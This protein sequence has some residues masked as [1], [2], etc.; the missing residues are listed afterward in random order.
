MTVVPAYTRALALLAI[1]ISAAIA[2]HPAHAQVSQARPGDSRLTSLLTPRIGVEVGA[3]ATSSTALQSAHTAILSAW[4]L[5]Y[6]HVDAA[7]SLAFTTLRGTST[8]RPLSLFRISTHHGPLTFSLGLEQST[9]IATSQ[10][11]T[12]SDTALYRPSDTLFSRGGIVDSTALVRTP[13]TQTPSTPNAIAALVRASDVVGG[14]GWNT[15]Y[16]SLQF[17][18]GLRTNDSHH[19]PWTGIDAALYLGE[20]NALTFSARR[21]PSSASIATPAFTLGFRSAY[22]HWGKRTPVADPTSSYITHARDDR[23]N[24]R[25]TTTDDTTHLALYLPT[26]H[27]IAVMGD[28][29]DWTS[30]DMHASGDGWWHVSLHITAT[31]S[32]IQLKTDADTDWRPIPGLTA[33]RDEYGGM[34]SLLNNI[35]DP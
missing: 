14:L 9:G 1:T 25:V 30:L 26:A 27:H 15:A 31:P 12:S 28:A 17:V 10:R 19:T 32:R 2:A 11:A 16:T 21:Q 22:W 34:V 35:L 7:L 4:D 8:T 24:V 20:S 23:D 29:T 13:Q 33:T 5:P 6:A 18:T 3:H